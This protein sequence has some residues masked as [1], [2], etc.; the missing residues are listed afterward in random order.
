MKKKLLALL[1]AFV[2]VAGM[3]PMTALAEVAD[4]GAQTGNTD[5]APDE[6]GVLT[7]TTAEQLT[8]GLSN[9]GAAT[10]KLGGDITV[11][12]LLTV[13]RGLTLD[14]AGHTLTSSVTGYAI[15]VN[16]TEKVAVTSSGDTAGKLTVSNGRGIHT[17]KAAENETQ[18]VSDIE[19]NNIEISTSTWALVNRAGCTMTVTNCKVTA[20]GGSAVENNADATLNATGTTFKG[21]KWAVINRANGTM[22]L[23]GGSVEATDS[24]AIENNSSATMT[25]T[26]CNVTSAGIVAVN[27][28]AGT[29]DITG[30]A[31]KS[32][33]ETLAN[34]VNG[35]MN[36]SGEAQVS[37]TGT[38]NSSFAIMNNGEMNITGGTYETADGAAGSC[39]VILCGSD[40]AASNDTK[41]VLTISNATVTSRNGIGITS[42]N[43][44]SVAISDGANIT[45][46]GNALGG[47]NTKPSANTT[48]EGTAQ[49]TSSDDAAIYQA[50][51]GVLKITGGEMTGKAG[52]VVRAGA[53]EITSGTITANGSGGL[54]VGDKTGTVPP[55][56]VVYDYDTV[57]QGNDESTTTLVKI[58][59]GTIMAGS[60]Q[61]AVKFLSPEGSGVDAKNYLT[62]TGGTFSSKIDDSYIGTGYVALED[63]GTYTVKACISNENVTVAEGPYTYNGQAQTPEVTVKVGDT[64][65]TKETDYTV[66][67]TNNTNAGDATITVTGVGSYGGA[68]TKTFTITQAVGTVTPA[69]ETVNLKVDETKVF[70]FTT[71]GEVTATGIEETKA[72]ATV[73]NEAKTV[74]IKGVSEGSTSVTIGAAATTNYTA[75]EGKTITVTVTD[76]PTTPTGLDITFDANGGKW[77]D[78]SDAKTATTG[79]DGKLAA[80]DIPA[81]P[82][83]EGYTFA[84]W[85]TKE[86]GKGET[87]DPASV[88]FT[89]VTTLYAQWT[90]N[91]PTPPTS[92]D[93]KV[94]F[95]ANGG[96]WTDG[97]KKVVTAS[98]GKLTADKIPADPTFEDHS[99]NGWYTG[100]ESGDKVTVTANN[101]YTV[102]QDTTLFAHWTQNASGGDTPSTPDYS[103]SGSS[104][105]TTTTKNEDGST[106]TKTENKAT[107][108]VTE[109]TKKPDGSV[110]VVETKKDGTKTTTE[111][112]AEGNKSEQVVKPDGSSQTKIEKKD[113]STSTTTVDT[114]GQVRAEVSLSGKALE[115]GD[116]APVALPMPQVPVTTVR[117]TAPTVTVSL[118]AGTRSAKV[119]IPV[120]NVT[121]GSVAI[122]VKADGTE[123]VIKTSVT[124]E[125]GIAVTLNDG[126]TV[127]IV[128]N[129]KTFAD[130]E[131]HWGSD[132]V[133]FAS[134]RELFNGTSDTTFSPDVEMTRGMLVT[135]LARF[136][137]ADTTGG[138]KWYDKGVEWAL[139]NNVSDGTDPEAE[140]T[141]EQMVTMIWRYAGSPAV[142][143]SSL[144]G[145][146]DTDSVS[147]YAA[148]AMNW[149]VSIG[150]INGMGD[151]SLAPQGSAT[152]AQVATVLMRYVELLAAQ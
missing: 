97:D 13:S 17:P 41:P 30:G 69:D 82:T 55:C 66:A 129:S 77:E 140:I 61:D 141:R 104:T 26:G 19:V 80:A 89:E 31:F 138:D 15:A 98:D 106:T 126:D 73:D 114:E 8:S 62:I 9:N 107:G 108:T 92:T 43:G 120:E 64:I 125:N 86:D 29:V 105:T 103:G 1:L 130:V 91:S 131:N 60:G 7:A 135:V 143:G 99:F 20:S 45:A 79:S 4:D 33:G 109:T 85:N 115:S 28:F 128:D 83:R 5:P 10:V 96:K 72:T 23:T 84:S 111:T 151:N 58:S 112:D 16:T 81:N 74:T 34:Q 152:R 90:Q 42:A 47:N 27:N 68:V 63:S 49:L 150:L 146:A 56:G 110:T 124:T 102:T 93:F 142:T 48:I 100:A 22:T 3:L 57:Y 65:L 53:V 147:S 2:M 95:D 148:D 136:D 88:V 67:Y 149:A 94:T 25:L 35:T 50:A 118:P 52:I 132:A 59:G 75:V 38:T 14:L 101:P 39:S 46:K 36:V 113:G 117:E 54:Q 133:N 44:G 12:S 78:S 121:P 6:N 119:E 37:A 144:G 127:K 139:E 24:F 123:E 21:T 11:S 71:D 40:D 51:S 137:G 76:T 145:F 70:T 32:T 134:S 18:I 87:K 116:N 122:I